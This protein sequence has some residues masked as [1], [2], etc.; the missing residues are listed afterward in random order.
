MAK[1]ERYNTTDPTTGQPALGGGASLA[2][3]L[4]LNVQ[5]EGALVGTVISDQ[6]G[7]LYVDQSFDYNWQT[8]T[9]DWDYTATYAVTAG[10]G[11]KISESV[12]AP[13]MRIRYTNGAT[14]QSYL[15][16]FVRAFGVKTG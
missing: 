10:V 12:I 6:T 15:R 16:I 4:L 13:S 1:F 5:Q 14:P 11:V 7:T 8:G 3:P 9:G 2:S